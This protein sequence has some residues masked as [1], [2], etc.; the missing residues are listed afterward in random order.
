MDL[1][2]WLI[3]TA[4]LGGAIVMAAFS[5]CVITYAL[6]LRWIALGAQE[7]DE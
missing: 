3:D 6:M 2:F 4:T 1:P 7:E 5:A